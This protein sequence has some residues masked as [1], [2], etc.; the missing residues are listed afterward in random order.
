MGRRAATYACLHS[1][2]R[3]HARPVGNKVL[4]VIPGGFI[5]GVTPTAGGV[6]GPAAQ[7]VAVFQR[8]LFA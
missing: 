7:R 4:G 6:E 3:P 8:G 1:A 2:G 5:P